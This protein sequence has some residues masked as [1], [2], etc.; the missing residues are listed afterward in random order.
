MTFPAGESPINYTPEN[1]RVLRLHHW[2]YALAGALV[3][4][5]LWSGKAVAFAAGVLV[6]LLALAIEIWFRRGIKNVVYRRSLNVRRA[7]IGDS[8]TLTVRVENHKR[9]PLPWLEVKCDM[10]AALEPI[11]GKTMAAARWRRVNVVNA[12]AVG[13]RQGVQRSIPLFCAARGLYWLGPVTSNSADPFM[14]LERNEEIPQPLASLLVLPLVVPLD[15][16]RLTAMAPFGDLPTKLKL[17]DDPTRM[18]GVRDYQRGDDPRFIHWKATAKASDLRTKLFDPA[19]RYRF[20]IV[21]E[22]NSYASSRLGIDPALLELSITVAGS[23]ACWALGEGYDTGLLANSPIPILPSEDGAIGD[24]P[25]EKTLDDARR[26]EMLWFPPSSQRVQRDKILEGLA[27]IQQ[28]SGSPI[29]GMVAAM[30][31]DFLPGTTIVLV[32]P[33]NA[34]RRDTTEYLAGLKNHGIATHLVLLG[35]RLESLTTPTYDLP[36]HLIGGREVW[37]ELFSAVRRGGQAAA[38]STKRFRLG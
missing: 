19:G 20:I 30:R 22:V 6:A 38:A 2:W 35:D 24:A 31:R 5:S 16:V 29:E 9:M 33:L 11:G 27:R 25:T 10:P 8:V 1:K 23:I 32:S 36:V 4:T 34:V 37:Y 12:F 28:Y 13:G 3:A 18:I 17:V 21:L 26:T 15:E 7:T 14:W